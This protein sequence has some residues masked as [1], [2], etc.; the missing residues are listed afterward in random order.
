[1]SS[2]IEAVKGEKTVASHFSILHTS[3]ISLPV[4]IDSYSTVAAHGFV[5]VAHVGVVTGL[6]IVA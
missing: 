1:M 2:R 6:V 3:S 4:P 5:A